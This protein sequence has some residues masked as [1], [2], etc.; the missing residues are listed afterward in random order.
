VATLATKPRI[1]FADAVAREPNA[2][3]A[4]DSDGSLADLIRWVVVQHLQIAP[5]QRD[6]ILARVRRLKTHGDALAYMKEVEGLVSTARVR[7][8]LVVH[9]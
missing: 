4:N 7:A 6:A 3:L 8:G 9:A 1:A 2:L 5:K